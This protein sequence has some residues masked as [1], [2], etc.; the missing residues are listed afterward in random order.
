MKQTFVREHGGGSVVEAN[1]PPEALLIVWPSVEIGLG[2]VISTITQAVGRN[3]A[4]GC[5]LVTLKPIL[6]TIKVATSLVA[7]AA[8]VLIELCTVATRTLVN[9]FLSRA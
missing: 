1:P 6:K 2:D 7:Q 3:T 5:G 4:A 9:R 8:G